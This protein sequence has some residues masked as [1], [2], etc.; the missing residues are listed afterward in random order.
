MS[1]MNINIISRDNGAGLTADTKIVTDIFTD[2]GWRVSFNDYKSLKRFS[3]W[4]GKVYDLN[5][6]MQWANPT[7]LKLAKK[8]VLI[9][10]PEWFKTKWISDLGKFD[11]I[12]CKTKIAVE[13]FK[14]KNPNTVFTSFT[15]L[16]KHLPGIPKAHDRWLHVAGKSK[17]KGTN[18][19]LETWKRNPHFPHLT[20]IQRNVDHSDF[21]APNLTCISEYVEAD[22][23]QRLMNE[24]AVHLCPSVTEGFGHSIGEAL[25]CGAAII[26]TDAPPMNE[27]VTENR[28]TLVKPVRQKKIQLSYA[29]YIDRKG[30]EESVNRM[31]ESNRLDEMMKNALSFYRENNRDFKARLIEDIKTL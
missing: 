9:P 22:E 26:A 3:L 20:I 16:D 10:N 28:G 6:F 15:S 14:D 29:Y 19:I 13:A 11:K 1:V 31:M 30:L 21:Q 7:W 27:L 18:V 17:L 12:L 24:C 4:R 23:L 2:Q 5:V 8:N 25:S